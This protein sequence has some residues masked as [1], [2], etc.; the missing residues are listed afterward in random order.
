MEDIEMEMSAP[1]AKEKSEETFEPN[2]GLAQHVFRQSTAPTAAREAMIRK[3]IEDGF[4]APYYAHV[5]GLF[6]WAVDAG[7]AARM[8]AANEA[9]AAYLAAKEADAL[10]N[11]GDMEVLDALFDA[12]KFR[13]RIG[14][15]ENAYAAADA[16]RDRPKISTG[17]RID[18]MMMKIRVALF[19]NDVATC[20]AQLAEAKKIG[21]DGG[22]WDRNNRLSV[23]ESLFLIVNRDIEAAAKKLL[24]G[25]ATFTCVELCAYPEFVFYAVLT[26]LLTLSRPELKKAIIDGP[27]VL[28]VIKQIPAL[29]A[30]VTSCYECDYAKYFQTIPEIEKLLENDRYLARHA[31]FVVRELR[32]LVYCQFLVAYKSVTLASMAE[33][34]G[35][36]VEFLD[37]ELARFVACGRLPAKVDKVANVVETNRPDYKSAKYQSIIKS[38]DVLLNRIQQLAR[39][40]SI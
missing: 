7:L 40:V 2:M 35:V 21:E 33:T 19:F 17:K 37:G 9:E 15:K 4:M 10:A 34:F 11:R 18:A 13:A 3:S 1:G 36:S 24:G 14:D 30:L 20:K 28:Q 8:A 29:A 5:C 12:V 39:V 22:D 16:I 27:E 32:V 25:V 31:R 38:G 26:N 6:G 23:Y